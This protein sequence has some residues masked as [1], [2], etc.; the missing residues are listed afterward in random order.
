MR[1]SPRGPATLLVLS[2]LGTPAAARAQEPEAVCADNLGTRIEVDALAGAYADFARAAEIVGRTPARPRLLRRSAPHGVVSLCGGEIPWGRRLEPVAPGGPGPSLHILPVTTAHEFNSAYPRDRNNGARWAGR[3]LS[4][5]LTGGV[6]LRWGPFSA[7]VAPELNHHQNRAFHIQ[8]ARVHESEGFSAYVYPGHPGLIDLPQRFG[9]EPFSSVEPG[10]SYVR[11]AGRGVAAG[12]STENVWWGPAMEQPILLGNSAPGFPHVFLGTSRPI[13]IGI[14]TLSA[15]SFWGRLSES[16]YFDSD[17]DNDHRLFAGLG[18][19][20]QPRS[21]EELSLGIGRMYTGPMRPGT[22]SPWAFFYEPYYA[23][24]ENRD[25]DNELLGVFARWVFPESDVE[26]YGEWVREDH[27]ADMDD[28]LAEPDHTLGYVVGIQKVVRRG[29]RW[30][31]LHGELFRLQIGPEPY[32]SG[33]G[34]TTFFTHNRLPQG[35]THRGQM[36]G[37][38][39]GPGSGGERIA[40]D[41]FTRHGLLGLFFGR[42][43]YDEDAYYSRHLIQGRTRGDNRD[44]ELTVGL[45]QLYFLGDFDLSWEASWS[46]RRNRAFIGLSREGDGNFPENNVG[47]ELGASWRPG[48]V[49]W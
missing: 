27:W 29:S 49:T 20:F 22:L 35:Y 48:G 8:P 28:L 44:R 31:R 16:D 10:Q 26:I 47:L 39:A 38:P 37:A 33:R 11:V 13:G 25:D 45:R 18:F 46:H 17:T 6:R 41:L 36:L 12:V 4:S 24:L 21:L 42:T 32:R 40:A 30:L 9:D 7:Q 1:R 5:T 2:L 15:T 34:I 14:G 23:L 19:A 43:S 3:G